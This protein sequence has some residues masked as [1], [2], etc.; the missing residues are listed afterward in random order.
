[1]EIPPSA[2]RAAPHVTTLIH[3]KLADVRAR[4]KNLAALEAEL[5]GVIERSHRLDPTDCTD[6]DI[7]NILSKPK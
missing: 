5:E 4:I 6:T 3:S 1:M 7:C 2:G